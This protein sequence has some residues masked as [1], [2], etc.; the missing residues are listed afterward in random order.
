MGQEPEA[1]LLTFIGT[2]NF[3]DDYGVVKASAVWLKS[4]IF[5]YKEKLRIDVFTTWLKRLEELEVVIPVA[6]RGECFYYIRT[7]RKYQKVDRPSKARNIPEDY[8]VAELNAKGFV[9]NDEEELVK[10]STSPR[11]TLDEPSLLEKEGEGEKE[12]E[13]EGGAGGASPPDPA[14]PKDE[15]FLARKQA[16]GEELIPFIETYGKEMIRAFF[17]YWS[18]PNKGKTKM[19]MDL[20]RTWDLSRRLKTW[21]DRNL[22]WDKTPK[23]D[24]KEQRDEYTAR[25][26][27]LEAKT[28]I[29]GS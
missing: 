1:I 2:W 19:R 22:R 4:Q 11:H 17:D 26:Q 3:A 12:G 23:S 21:A 25:R 7:F 10:H 14:I 8:L 28:K 29:A 6:Y 27:K 24:E 16:F 13:E 5:P 20:E 9:F 18:E 15:K